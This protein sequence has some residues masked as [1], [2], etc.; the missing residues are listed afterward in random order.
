MQI[1]LYFQTIESILKHQTANV[2]DMTGYYFQTI[3]S[4]LKHLLFPLDHHVLDNFQTIESILKR[5]SYASMYVDS[6]I[7][8]LLSLF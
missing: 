1:F 2:K 7:S 4:I 5:G 8:R 6:M 3:E